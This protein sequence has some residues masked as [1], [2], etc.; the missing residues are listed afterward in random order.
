MSYINNGNYRYGITEYDQPQIPYYNSTLEHK[1]PPLREFP[2]KAI[3]DDGEPYKQ[4][5]L[6]KCCETCKKCN[7]IN[8]NMIVNNFVNI[9]TYI[10]KI[11][12]VTLYGLTKEYDKTIKL[13]IGNKYCVTYITEAGIQTITGVF[14]ELSDNIPDNCLR[15]IGN[16]NSVTSAA[17]IGLDC[18]TIGASDKRLI[19][20]A[21][22]RYIEEI[23]DEDDDPY[24]SLT[25]QEKIIKLYTD[26]Q[27]TLSSINKYIEDNTKSEDEEDDDS[28][29]QQQTQ[30][31]EDED[32]PL[33]SE[34]IISTL[35]DMKSML[36]S[37]I[38]TYISEEEY[39]NSDDGCD[40]DDST[41]DDSD[42]ENQS[43]GGGTDPDN[44]NAIV[45]NDEPDEP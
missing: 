12:T 5:I 7:A 17:Y 33:V 45:T 4:L 11:L 44:S 23:F 20:I 19:Y 15:Y 6:P 1:K 37:F 43:S 30:Q 22:I 34:D 8:R 35:T 40:C 2:C 27:T 10:D 9:E 25:Q 38:T 31:S 24:A 13:K 18:S 16:F 36:S 28:T 26:I 14:K 32:N 41:N 39:K 3:K 42:D 21:S 29:E